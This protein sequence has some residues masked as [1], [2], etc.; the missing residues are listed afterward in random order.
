MSRIALVGY[1]KMGRTI[2]A[3]A[4][5]R[6]HSISHKIN[7]ENQADIQLIK[8]D[9]TDIVI[10]FSQPESAFDN[11]MACLKNG[12]PT[13]SGT[14]GWLAKKAAVEAYCQEVNGTFLYASNFSIGVNI[15]FK[16]N[17][18]LAQMMER[19]A[20]YD[21]KMEEIHHTH[22]KDAPSGTAI[23]LAEGIIDGLSRKSNW[24]LSTEQPQ[25]SDIAIEAL[26]IDE[27]PGTHSVTYHSPIDEIEIKHTAHTRAGFAQGAVMV[28]EWIKDKKGVLTM[29]DFLNF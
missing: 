28:A 12:V 20:D 29:N 1:G 14:T 21:V 5:E 25:A 27:V 9:N 13:I 16:L 19:Y 10:E 6:G 3:I 2:E 7:I 26:R 18:Q 23:T 15:F 8:P 22:K 17:A 24:K 4:L 11:I